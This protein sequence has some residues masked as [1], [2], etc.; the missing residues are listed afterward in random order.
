MSDEKIYIALA[1]NARRSWKADEVSQLSQLQ[2]PDRI[3]GDRRKGILRSDIA[4]LWV[5]WFVESLIDPQRYVI[6]GTH[7]SHIFSDVIKEIRG[8]FSHLTVDEAHELA[9]DISCEMWTRVNTLRQNNDR[10]QFSKDVRFDLLADAGERPRCWMCG[11]LFSTAAVKAFEEGKNSQIPAHEFV[12]VYKPLGLR[13]VDSTI[14][15]DHVEAWSHGGSDSTDNL[16]LSCAWCNRNKSA[17]RSIYDVSGTAV[18]ARVNNLK[19]YSL[20]QHFWTIRLIAAVRRCEHPDGC[21]CKVENSELTV[22]PV[23]ING[24]ATPTNLRVV[25]SDHHYLKD[26]RL[27]PRKKVAEIWDKNLTEN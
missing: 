26:K 15:I 10:T 7:Y 23:N 12:D 4:I 6:D 17:H 13:S 25:C 2:V 14:Q 24:V 21:S 16:R 8:K 19:I 1:L 5:T 9:S 3:L 22:E 18:S 11:H 27:L 20:P